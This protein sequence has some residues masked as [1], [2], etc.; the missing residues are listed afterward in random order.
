MLVLLK[1][2]SRTVHHY[3]GDYKLYDSRESESESESEGAAC[4]SLTVW[5]KSL[6]FNC[7]GFTVIGSDG[8]LVYRV[9]N[10]TSRPHQIILMDASGHPIF[11]I[12]RPK[13]CYTIYTY[14]YIFI[15]IYFQCLII[16]STKLYMFSLHL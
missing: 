14:T 10:Y 12:C 9:D 4:N 8:S 13:V 5:R 3:H 11:T 6:V 16:I 7:K 1:P 15:Y 2:R